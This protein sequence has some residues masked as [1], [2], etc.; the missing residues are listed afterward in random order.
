MSRRQMLGGLFGA[1]VAPVVKRL[2][3][4][5][6]PVPDTAPLIAINAP[7]VHL[8]NFTIEGGTSRRAGTAIAI[9]A[10][11]GLIEKGYIKA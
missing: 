5:G 2:D 10:S 6:E 3:K 7:G 8:S 4:E 9:N 11:H 1:A